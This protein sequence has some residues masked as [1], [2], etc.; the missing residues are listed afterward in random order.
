MQTL[1]ISQFATRP[2][3]GPLAARAAGNRELDWEITAN[4]VAG[5]IVGV[6]FPEILTGADVHVH[7][8]AGCLD[9]FPLPV[10]P[11]PPEDVGI[12]G[13]RVPYLHRI[14]NRAGIWIPFQCQASIHHELA[15]RW[16]QRLEYLAE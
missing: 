11:S 7:W 16:R 4:R 12:T 2:E 1:T 6:Y 14:V 10:R 8:N 15:G 5:A 3:Y 13:S 9:A